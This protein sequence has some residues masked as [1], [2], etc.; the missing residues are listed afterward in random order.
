ML[1][2]RMARGIYHVRIQAG[3]ALGDREAQYPRSMPENSCSQN[4]WKF[5]LFTPKRGKFPLRLGHLYPD[6]Q[7]RLSW[8][9][10][11]SSSPSSS[12]YTWA[13]WLSCPDQ[14]RMRRVV[15]GTPDPGRDCR[16]CDHRTR[17]REWIGPI[18]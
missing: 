16:R 13:S 7:V 2:S 15:S 5:Q 4:L 11:A 9:P 17:A 1:L 18:Y 12:F 6:P 3:G 14:G 8:R 10:P